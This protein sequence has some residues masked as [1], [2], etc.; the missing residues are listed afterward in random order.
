MSSI[1]LP[2]TV[3]SGCPVACT[4]VRHSHAHRLHCRRIYI[5]SIDFCTYASNLL[6]LDILLFLEP[7][8]KIL[9]FSFGETWLAVLGI[10]TVKL[11][12]SASGARLAV[13]HCNPF[14]DMFDKATDSQLSGLA[15][16]YLMLSG[17]REDDL[18]TL[19]A[20]QSS[21]SRSCYLIHLS[22]TL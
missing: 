20:G 13:S 18:P 21:P 15:D 19:L 11:G 22:L 7:Y 1:I 4:A 10:L 17:T 14:L 12:D 5:I 6:F 16:R 3:A 2:Y 8:C 9:K